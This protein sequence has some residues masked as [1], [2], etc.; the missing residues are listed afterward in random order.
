MRV[1]RSLDEVAV[2]PHGTPRAVAIG[3]FDGVHVGHQRIIGM[4][5][6]AARAM[7]GVSTVV[8]FEPHPAMVLHPE[9]APAILTPLEVKI[10]LLEHLGVDEVIAI[11]FT[12]EFAALSPDEFCGRL[13]S[14]RLGARQVS[15][16]ANFRFGRQGRGGAADLLSFGQAQGFSVS[17]IH[18]IEAEG[19]VVSSTR[20]RRLVAEGDVETAARLLT[21]PHTLVGRVVAGAGRGRTMGMPTAN[22][23]P[24][25]DAAVPAL[26]VYATRT[27][28]PQWPIQDSV[29]SVGTN[30][31]FENDNVVRIETFLLDFHG[32]LYDVSMGID[33]VARLRDQRTFSSKD[34]LVEQVQRDVEEARRR[35][36]AAP[37][38]P[39]GAPGRVW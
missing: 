10:D 27:R 16:G 15:V 14:Q 6:D 32:T 29:T 20:I 2:L 25:A 28:V 4:A 5:M 34:A 1:Y 26:G 7:Q 8:T 19:Q 13:L 37:A 31:T 38:G 36:A 22:M 24:P 3:T 30:P 23:E 18:L 17:A 21:R 33:F 35:L 12:R 9:S 11:P 39:S